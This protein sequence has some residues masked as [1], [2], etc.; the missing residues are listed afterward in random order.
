M[1]V[2]QFDFALPPAAIALRP[3]RPRDSAR[4]LHVANPGDNS[5]D[6][7]AFYD[8][9][10]GDLPDLL[11]PGDLLVFNNTR[12]L[13]LQLQAR[14]GAA[15]IELTLLQA[16]GQGCWQA[17]ARPARRLRAGD[18]LEI[19]GDFSATV[20]GPHADGQVV[21]HF[22][23]DD[24][25]LMAALERH[26]SLPLPPYIRK[27][28]AVDAR[29]KVDYQTV[30]ARHD[31]AVAAPTAGLH[32]TA[33]LLARLGQAGIGRAEVTLHVGAGTFRPVSVADTSQHVMHGEWGRVDEPVVQQIRETRAG[34]GRVVAVGTT[35]LRLLESAARGV[36]AGDVL[37]P[38]AGETDIFITPGFEFRV[39]DLLLTNFHLP[40]STL[41]MLVA[42]FA[43]LAR[44]QTAYAH[45]IQAGY[46]FYS[47]GDGCLLEPAQTRQDGR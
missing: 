40:R 32:F 27:H 10:I 29:D 33:G 23:L 2:D 9:L 12:V 14:R 1:D 18:R 47:Y 21:L 31:G 36:P 6:N 5:G 20:Q 30:L 43:G 39:V 26:G 28:R 37:A 3:A 38:F 11:R 44:M 35:S 16:L 22:A 45:A 41:F 34:G 19:A 24:A 17:F 8:R 46:R 42:A 13:P 7:G 25:A 4:L 15:R